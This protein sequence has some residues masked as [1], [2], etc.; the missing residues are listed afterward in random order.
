MNIVDTD[1]SL[2]G[3]GYCTAKGPW[4]TDKFVPFEG[5]IVFKKPVSVNKG[6]LRLRKDNPTGLPIH[7]DALEIP[8]FIR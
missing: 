5:T 3:Q 8:V 2:I 6:V 4:M 1:G 7:D